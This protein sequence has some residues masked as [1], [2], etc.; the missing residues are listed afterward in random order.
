MS[1]LKDG[2]RQWN[3]T[4]N[5]LFNKVIGQSEK[6]VF[7]FYLKTKQLFGQYKTQS[8]QYVLKQPVTEY[9]PHWH[10]S[11]VLGNLS[12][13]SHKYKSYPPI[14]P[15]QQQN[16]LRN[17]KHLDVKN[18]EH[19]YTHASRIQP[20]NTSLLWPRNQLCLIEREERTGRS[21]HKLIFQ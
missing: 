11:G 17:I 5:V 8:S 16:T 10:L 19:N 14:S 21:K 2:R 4:V 3:K 20:S 13:L 12:A 9:F 18:R 15:P 6:D 7:Y 1:C